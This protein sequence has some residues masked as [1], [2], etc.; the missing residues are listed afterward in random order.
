[1]NWNKTNVLKKDVEELQQ[2]YKTDAITASIL[3]RRGITK[4][5]DI[6][7]YLEDDLRYQHNPFLFNSME[8][9]VD[10][11][12]DAAE[13]DENGNSEKVLIFGDRDVDGVTATTIL[14][15]CLKSIGV[16]VQFRVP[17]GDDAY[18]LSI[19][20]ID[21]FASQYGSLI[22]TVDCGIANNN[23]IA[24]ATEKG[25]D[26]I[27]TDHHNPQ[28][29]VPED[30]II[31]NAKVKGSGYPFEEI[32]GCALTYK[33]ASALRF[34][35]SKWYKSDVTL[36]NA[37][38][39]DDSIVLECIKLRNLV[40]SSRLT[41]T[42]IPGEKSISDTKLPSY[43]Q[44]QLILCWDA[45]ETSTLLKQAFGGSADFNV[46]EM[47]NEIAGLFPQ[48]RNAD[49]SQIKEMSR[50]A[51]YGDHSPT[52]IGGFYNIFVTYVQQ[53]LKKENPS[54]VSA[55]EKDLQLVA[56]ASIADVM[57]LVDENRIFVRKGL[58]YINAGRTRKG[59][60][61][62]LSQLN[63]L[64]KKITSKDIGWS[65]DPKLN[66]A[67]RLGQASIAVDLFT[68]DDP[69]YR[70]QTAK[71]ILELNTKRQDLTLEAKNLTHQQAHDSISEYSNKLCVVYNEN[72]FKGVSGILAG[73]YVEEFGIPSIIMTSVGEYIVGSM[74]SCRNF[75][76][77]VFLEK[78]KDIFVSHGGHYFAAGFT[79]EKNDLEKFLSLLKANSS[80]IELSRE[81]DSSQNIDA[82]VPPQFMTPDLIKIVD[83][84]EP[85]GN[86][87][88]GI[89]FMS[90]NLP[91]IQA[92]TVGKTERTHLKL[93]LDCGKSKWPA[94]FWGAGD[95]LH[96]EIENGDKV[97]ILY[98]VERNTFNGIETLQ[99]NIKDLRKSI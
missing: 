98:S 15:E 39:E 29:N 94:L 52:E 42:I 91:V 66:A 83:Q 20:A 73:K 49:L 53:K 72:I 30:S 74:R 75:D 57:P 16:D 32:C 3:L 59:L 93:N 89:L 67:G 50:I 5:R 65:I 44:G 2:K 63:L 55:E 21:E 70:E 23:E 7:Y 26:V 48:L 69:T 64:G 10:R 25:I 56:L 31:L 85:Y 22:I 28:E 6:F 60:V 19:E 95:M 92:T 86:E 40:P 76:V 46:L 14:Y 88:D 18:G 62:L 68:S 90:R 58:E 84:F 41:E 9:A 80:S 81:E 97:D 54:F 36:L 77:T 35:R 47:K 82:E 96:R 71:Q 12:L 61:E 43:L 27:V 17:Q 4:G 1:M 37:R 8:D 87:N 34:S 45:K 51:R 38:T 79:I 78:M 13:K 24:Y 33:L 11:I 99:L